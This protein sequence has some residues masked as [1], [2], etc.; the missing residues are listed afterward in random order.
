MF[1][2]AVEHDLVRVQALF[3]QNAHRHLIYTKSHVYGLTYDFK[4]GKVSLCSA[5]FEATRNNTR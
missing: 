4:L 2:S 5:F 3:A 1:D